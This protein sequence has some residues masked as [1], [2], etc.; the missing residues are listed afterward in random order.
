[1]AGTA[2]PSAASTIITFLVLFWSA[3]CLIGRR[4]VSRQP[5][6]P[7]TCY[8]LMPH[9]Q[10]HDIARA[11]GYVLCAFLVAKE[12]HHIDH[13]SASYS[14]VRLFPDLKPDGKG[15]AQEMSYM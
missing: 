1:M 14:N 4:R 5:Q 11:P 3:A 9:I 8:A 10:R 12:R 15:I 7:Q 2:L 6:S 13:Y